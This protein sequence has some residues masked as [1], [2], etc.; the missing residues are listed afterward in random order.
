MLKRLRRNESG[1]LLIGAIVLLLVVAISVPAIISYVQDESRWT[2]RQLRTTRAFQLA[3]GAVEQGYQRVIISTTIWGEVQAGIAQTGYNFDQTY[4]STSG[5]CEVK[6]S[7]GPGDGQVTIL[8]VGRDGSTKEIRGVKAIY[9]DTTSN[10]ALYAMRGIDLTSNPNV[11]WGLVMSPASIETDKDSPRFYSAG[12]I[13]L[14][15]NAGI[16]PNSD[17][18]QWW[19]YY[20]NLPPPP[21]VD[22]QYYKNNATVTLP[23]GYANNLGNVGSTG[24]PAIV[25]SAGNVT[26]KSNSFIT[27]ALVV[28]GD[29]TLQG[30][31]GSGSYNANIP[32]TAWKE[33]GKNAT[34]WAQYR[35]WDGGAPASFPGLNSGYTPSG[36][37]TAS[38]N[39]VVCRGFMYVGGV[40]SISGGGN[41]TV[42][43]SMFNPGNT[44]L[45]GSH[46][47]IYYD[48][49]TLSA[50]KTLNV[51]LARSS[52][53][54]VG[55][56][57]WAT[58]PGSHP[59]CP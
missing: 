9:G 27:G 11:E 42:N 17:N 21:Q 41:C 22:V 10:A 19:S 5:S 15:T 52:W 43:G 2:T 13:S 56:C 18:V 54:E 32:S 31:A 14:D 28:I 8:G 55:G 49:S 33:Y 12:S 23:A 46:V 39:N 20:A 51:S 47:K 59:S 30:S 57:S 40:F 58:T 24:S 6:V 48:D 7:S 26:L 1:Q 16:P 38:I 50:P 36:S 53:E 45:S 4:T 3:E 34:T 37:L 25:Y 29:L 35:S 44:D